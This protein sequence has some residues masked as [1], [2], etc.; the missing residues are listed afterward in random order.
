MLAMTY[1]T[2]FA[3]GQFVQTLEFEKNLDRL[4]EVAVRV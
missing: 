4:A 1:T 3:K 2:A